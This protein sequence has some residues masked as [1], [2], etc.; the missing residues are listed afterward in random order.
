MMGPIE[1]IKTC[2]QKFFTYKGRARRSEF[3]WFWLF[4]NALSAVPVVIILNAMEEMSQYYYYTPDSIITKLFFWGFLTLLISVPLFFATIRRLHDIDYS[5]WWLL[6]VFIPVIGTIVWLGLLFLETL[7]GTAED[8]K[9]G[10]S[11]KYVRKASA[12]NEQTD[13][14]M[15]ANTSTNTNANSLEAGASNASGAAHAVEEESVQN[16]DSKE[17]SNDPQ[18]ESV[19]QEEAVNEDEFDEDEF[20]EPEFDEDEEALKKE[21]Q[22]CLENDGT[23]TAAEYKYIESV[24]SRL[25][26]EKERVAEIIESCKPKLSADE[27]R[28]VDFYRDLVQ[29][30]KNVDS[31]TKRLLDREAFTNGITPERQKELENIANI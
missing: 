4:C 24:A 16:L 31:R 26:I 22:F 21:I 18:S 5:G 3:W 14:I 15:E 30:P 8:N 11:P 23:L 19:E 27:Q 10:P 13:N 20:G 1:S 2:Y 7:D 9:Y 29:D 28:Y 25:G 17:Q 6:I 12:K